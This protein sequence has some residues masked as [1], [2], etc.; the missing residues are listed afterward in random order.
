MYRT[1]TI[2][3]PASRVIAVAAGVFGFIALV[4]AIVGTATPSWYYINISGN[5]QY[6][7]FFTQCVGSL[8]ND[9][10]QCVDM[11]RNTNL[12]L[13]T[14]H[15]GALAVVGLIFLGCG[16]IIAFA[17][18]CMQ[19]SGI[20][21]LIS[22]ILLFLAS[23]FMLA[24]LAEGSRVTLYNSYSANLFQ[25]AHLLTFFSMGLAAFAAGEYF[26]NQGLSAV[27]GAIGS[28]GIQDIFS[29]FTSQI[30][31]LVQDGQT[32]LNG[33]VSNLTQIVSGVLDA[34]KTTLGTITRSIDGSWFECIELTRINNQRFTWN[35]HR[36][37]LKK[38]G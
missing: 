38:V 23:L 3:D 37:S 9:T 13:I 24:S 4:L 15:A 30:T 6:Y 18:A 17:M 19:F 36:W 27:L 35:N 2:V 21:S 25:T 1:T 10:S 33:V 26:L 28:R 31:T 20:L 12:G 29:G 11:Q 16:T 22:P 7:N 14:Q 8:V 32:A 5:T 34:S